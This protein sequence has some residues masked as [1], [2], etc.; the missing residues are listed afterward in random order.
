MA[1]YIV[2]LLEEALGSITERK[3]AI[4]G[5]AYK[6]GVSDIRMSPGLHLAEELQ[7]RA[8]H[9]PA[10]EARTDGDSPIQVSLHDPQ[11]TDQTLA[12]ETLEDAVLDADAIVVTTDHSE[13]ESLDPASIAQKMAGNVV[14]DTRA[15]LDEAEWAAADLDP[16]RV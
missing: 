5:V 2:D 14:V 16:I 3:I 6:G 10:V 8:L 13:Y 12:L 9:E 15:V 1:G 11:V 4:L 7:D